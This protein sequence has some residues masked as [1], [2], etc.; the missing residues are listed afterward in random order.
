MWDFLNIIATVAISGIFVLCILQLLKF[1]AEE[2]SW[3]VNSIVFIS[4]FINS[5]SIVIFPLD[6]YNVIFQF[7]T[8]RQSI[9]K[10]W[11]NQK[12]VSFGDGEE[13][14]GLISS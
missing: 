12:S 4:W 6:L 8:I 1:S 5:M 10:K 14:T 7:L 2:V 3:K 9:T 11:V 13:F